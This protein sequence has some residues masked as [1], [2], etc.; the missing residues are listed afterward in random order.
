MSG[1]PK[2]AA[3]F[4]DRDGTLV[5]DVGYLNCEEQLE[6][7]S[8]VPEAI[9]R[10]QAEGFKVVVVTNQSAVARGRLVESDLLKINEALRQRL[11]QSGAIL[12]GIYY[13]PHHPTEGLGSYRVACNCR[14]PNTGMVRRACEELGL[15][16]SI[17]YVVGDQETDM[18]LAERVGATGILICDP[19][20]DD[21]V[22]KV[23]NGCSVADLQHAVEWIL[24]DT[25]Q[26]RRK[27]SHR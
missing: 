16:P 24:K 22:S 9:R 7:L 6:I 17:S 21:Y 25:A 5:R 18:D 19:R 12:D 27:E 20:S 15:D 11:A 13:C 4:L 10:L 8:G 14:K 1:V 23:S 3:V 26:T 2:V